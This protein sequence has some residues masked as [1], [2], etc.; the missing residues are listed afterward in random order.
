MPLSWP[1]VLSTFFSSLHGS[2][3]AMDTSRTPTSLCAMMKVAAS[4]STCCYWAVFRLQLLCPSVL[5]V[6]LLFQVCAGHVLRTSPGFCRASMR[7]PEE[8]QNRVFPKPARFSRTSRS[9]KP[10][11]LQQPPLRPNMNSTLT[12]PKNAP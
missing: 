4:I 1:A 8:S 11:K 5:P 7:N 9:P 10:A 12:S 6:R 2:L 3:S